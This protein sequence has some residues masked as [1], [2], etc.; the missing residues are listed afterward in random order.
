VVVRVLVD[1]DLDVRLRHHFGE[2][3]EV[4]TVTYRGW[5]GLENGELL[6]AAETEFDVLVTM[7]TNIP[8]QRSLS[9][10]DIA[11]VILRAKSKRLEHLLEVMPEVRRVLSTVSAGQAVEVFPPSTRS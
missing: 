11:I 1:E 8:H 4:E 9:S 3:V 5:K 6:R 10:F 2:G 7:D